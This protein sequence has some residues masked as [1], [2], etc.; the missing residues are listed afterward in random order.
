MNPILTKQDYENM[1][2]SGRIA[3]IGMGVSHRELAQKLKGQGADLTVLD[4]KGDFPQSKDGLF[5]QSL[6]AKIRCGEDYLDHLSDFD[7]ILRSPG[8]KWHLPQLQKA[9]ENHLPVTTE[10]E[11]FFALCPAKI[12]GV[13]GSDGKTTSTTLISEFLKAENKK[14]FLGG[15]IGYPLLSK[16]DEIT[17]E[18]TVVAELSSFQLMGMEKSADVCL[19]T[20]LAPNHL[21]WHKDMEE[22][23][24]SKANLMMHQDEN[25]LT[26]LNEDNAGSMGY[27]PFVKGKLRTFSAVHP[28][29]NG[30]FV[31]EKGMICFTK[32]GSVTPLF[33]ASDIRLRGHF[34]L[35]N[36]LGAIAC[37]YPAVSKKTLH[38][39]AKD[40]G[41]V[42][43][44]NETVAVKDG[45]EWINDSIATSPTRTNAGLTLYDK[46]IILIAGGYDK[47]IPYAPLAG[48]VI[49]NVKHLILMGDTAD[50][51]EEAVKAHE[52]YK[53]NSPVIHRAKT[54]ED[55]VQI[56]ASLAVAGDIV[57]LSPASA[58][59]GL[60]RNF[61]ER[62]EH[63]RR[64]VQEL[65]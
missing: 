4:M 52:D 8:V 3:M 5:V 39:V 22:Y 34:N 42:A 13:T 7:L 23:T 63:F 35:E 32:D 24:R 31:D 65:V 44:R 12:Y 20:N 61:E 54:L 60:Y 26:V 40:F 64:L 33:P 47:K 25:G 46:K 58:S 51:I 27:L 17:K 43:H 56:A 1:I 6:G 36:M 45:V 28:V 30:S 49:Q 50:A 37:V 14:V 15:N 57:K 2:R 59:F 11:L 18:D 9:R 55:A 10:M 62:G 16:L 19:V 21:D 38:Q 41:G 53:E 48:P 29:E